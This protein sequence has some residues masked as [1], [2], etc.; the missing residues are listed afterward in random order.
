MEKS[1]QASERCRF[2]ENRREEHEFATRIIQYNI[3]RRT[4]ELLKKLFLLH[5]FPEQ[6][7]GEVENVKDFFYFTDYAVTNPKASIGSISLVRV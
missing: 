5:G 2:W 1:L 4:R 7:Y 3:G 6:S